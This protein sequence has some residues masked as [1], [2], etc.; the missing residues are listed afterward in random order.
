MM[1]LTIRT[2][3]PQAEVGLFNGNE[4]LAYQ[5]WQA[6]RELSA[7]IHIRISELLQAQHMQWVDIK[8]VVCF[9]G[10][11]SFTG[12][13]I[14]VSVA[15]ALAYG[16]G[17]PIVGASGSDWVAE[18]IMQLAAGTHGQTIVPDYGQDPYTTAPKK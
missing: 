11:G 6:H 8:G 16:L 15:N 2:D 18:G 5:P 10:P 3:S 12:L 4:K 7:T 17:V 13:R 14:G 1:I 9:K